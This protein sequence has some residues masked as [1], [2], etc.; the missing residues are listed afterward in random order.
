MPALKSL[1]WWW[2]VEVAS[3]GRLPKLLGLFYNRAPT[4]CKRALHT[5]GSFT[6]ETWPF[7]QPAHGCFELVAH[8]CHHILVFL[9]VVVSALLWHV[10]DGDCWMEIYTRWPRLIYCFNYLCRCA[11]LLK[12]PCET[13]CKHNHYQPQLVSTWQTSVFEYVCV[14]LCACMC[15]C[16]WVCVWV[17]VCM[18]VCMNESWRTY[19]WVTAHVRTS[20]GINTNESCPRM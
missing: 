5:W 4:N 16:V 8:C 1:S 6:R 10:R 3:T 15:V 11:L 18:C 13:T 9:G 7:R 2:L 14:C 19:E 12:I 20:R 17:C